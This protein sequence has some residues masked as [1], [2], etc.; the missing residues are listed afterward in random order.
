MN[1]ALAPADNTAALKLIAAPT[2]LGRLIQWLTRAG[3]GA[4]VQQKNTVMVGISIPQITKTRIIE[5]KR[6]KRTS[7]QPRALVPQLD[8]MPVKL[9]RLRI[10]IFPREEAA[11]IRVNVAGKAGFIAIIKAGYAWQ[12]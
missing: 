5:I 8:R 11:V 9:H 6:L 2:S 4:N 3:S 12:C 7:R 10:F 1:L